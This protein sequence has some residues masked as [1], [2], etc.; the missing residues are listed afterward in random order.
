MSDTKKNLREK[1][2]SYF[3]AWFNGLLKK[4]KHSA[5]TIT[6]SHKNIYILPSKF[7]LA[8]LFVNLLV[9]VLGI[10]Y[11]NNLVIMFS[12]LMLSFLLVNFIVAFINLYNLNITLSHTSA[13]YQN[14]GYHA[15]F[16]L[17]NRDG[18]TS[19]EIEGENI[20]SKFID[21][22]DNQLFKLNIQINVSKRGVH[23]LPRIKLLSRYPFGLVTTWSYFVSEV[24]TYIYPTPLSYSIH[25]VT[26]A[27]LEF[28]NDSR[29]TTAA[30]ENYQGVR[31]Y[32]EGDKVNRISWK[33]YAKHQ[34]LATK[35]FSAGSSNEYEFNLNTVPGN[36]EQ[37]LQHL[38]YLITHAEQESLRYSLVLPNS[39][40]DLNSGKN[41]MTECLER[42]SDV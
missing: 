4:R 35:D 39:K 15:Q 16:H 1:V 31:P 8:Y 6:L 13:G 40:V 18:T 30:S 2:N 24:Q 12:Y 25:Q 23:I 32:I 19:L 37:K 34:V 9:Y 14:T 38:S 10:N 26:K 41:H 21:A 33:H 7:G 11:Q 5:K 20:Q 36:L 29:K 27:E 42:L 3:N 17:N 22:I 28:E